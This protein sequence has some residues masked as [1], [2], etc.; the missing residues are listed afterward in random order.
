[1][2]ND[3][4]WSG[5]WKAWLV[6][7][8]VASTLLRLALGWLYLGFIS[9]DDVEMLE[10]GVAPVTDLDYTPW[11]IRNLLLP[12]LLVTPVAWIASRVGWG[13]AALLV[14]LAVLPFVALAT[15]NVF[16]I[17]LVVRR[18]AG[19][20]EGVVAAAVYGFH[21]L[22]LGFGAT[23]YPR[24]VSTTCILVAF[25]L[26]LGRGR[27]VLR[28]L[29]AGAFMALAFA[30]RYSEAVYLLPL[31][32]AGPVLTTDERRALRRNA[33]LGGGFLLGAAAFTG[34]TDLLTWG[35]P[36]R[37][38]VEFT[39]YT[40]VEQD[41]ASLEPRQP[42]LWYLS[43]AQVWLIPT[44][45]PFLVPVARRQSRLQTASWLMLVVPV[46]LL[47]LIHHKEL[48]YLQGVVPFLAILAAAGIRRFWA[49]GWR[50]TT[51]ALLLVSGLFSLRAAVELHREKSLSA[52]RAALELR[53]DSSV[54]ALVVIQA[55]AYGDRLLL[56]PGVTMVNFETP[57]ASGELAEA[58]A[59]ADAAAFY[60]E[61]LQ[62]RPELRQVLDRAGL[63]VWRRYELADSR[64]VAVFR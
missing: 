37:S 45:V 8:L 63:E 5:D 59:R 41:S 42:T 58:L 36:F 35:E 21:W 52:V 39:R 4:R 16:L 12:R 46:V 40:L 34:L 50:K 7:V 33:A 32:L 15:L 25:Y 20:C 17:H 10:T 11:G 57:P 47:S 56:G 29:A 3:A 54:D 43:H 31:A 30:A 18:A 62:A 51:V 19:D 22:P 14:R 9:G 28:G 61:D 64:A 38:L 24:T 13:D 49:R 2:G 53:E 48:R 55:W 44:L 26:L 27:D 6:V 23:V 1:V 60:E